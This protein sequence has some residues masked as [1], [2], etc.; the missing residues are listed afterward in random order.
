[1]K[2]LLIGTLFVSLCVLIACSGSNATKAT[3]ADDES[4]IKPVKDP[5]DVKPMALMMRTMADYCDSM[6]L[7]INAGK[8]VDSVKYPLMPFWTVEPTDSNVLETLFFSNAHQFAATYRQLMSSSENQKENYTAVINQ[9][10]HCHS[11]Y[12]S[13]PLRRIKT[14]TLDYQPG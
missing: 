3:A 12:C 13:G 7:E 14:L 5:N 9:C 8:A 10:V 1:M 6:R 2:N 11:S 4:C